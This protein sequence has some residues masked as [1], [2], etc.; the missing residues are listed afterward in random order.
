[1]KLAIPSHSEPL[2][3][4]KIR[5]VANQAKL[6]IPSHSEPLCWE[7]IGKVANQAKLAILSHS[8]PLR[9]EKIGKVVN[10]VK[11]AI[12]SH[13]EPLWWEKI[14]KVATQTKSNLSGGGVGGGVHHPEPQCHVDPKF[15]LNLKNRD[16]LFSAFHKLQMYVCNEG[17]GGRLVKCT[18]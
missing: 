2:Q 9:W 6:A 10:Q 12:Q 3:W 14:G 15:Q 1:M 18:C 17:G 7:K 16:F 5:K 13:Y 8:E 4:G 11:L